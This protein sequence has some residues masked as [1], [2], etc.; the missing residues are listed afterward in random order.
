[1]KE[2]KKKVVDKEIGVFFWGCY[3]NKNLSKLQAFGKW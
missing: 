2:E 1:M 3:I